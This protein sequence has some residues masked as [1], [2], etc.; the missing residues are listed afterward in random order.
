MIHIL[1]GDDEFSIERVLSSMKSAVCDEQLRDVNITT[2]SAPGINFQEVISAIQTVPFLSAKRMIVLDGLLGMFEPVRGSKRSKKSEKSK[3]EEW[4]KFEDYFV[5]SPAG[6]EIVFIDKRLT[7]GNEL[8]LLIK[9]IAKVRLFQIPSGRALVDWVLNRASGYEL[10]IDMKVAGILVDSIGPNLRIIDSE[11]NK[12]SIMFEGAKVKEDDVRNV[13]AS[14]RETSIFAAVDA[15]IE[16]RAGMAITAT[17]RLIESGTTTSNLVA[18][19]AR[20]IR[21]LLLAKDHKAQGLPEGQLGKALKLSGYPLTKTIQQESNF[22]HENLVR[23]HAELV[24][25]DLQLKSMPIDDRVALEIA[26]T[27][28]ASIP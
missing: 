15:V 25:L 13:V 12:L 6:N 22:T 7:S 9:N 8:F 5:D 3:L 18:L 2:F 16:G 19:I 28:M 27:K 10:N 4:K 26:V 21:L 24:D 1:H 11:L 14:V 23:I 20:Q 17:R